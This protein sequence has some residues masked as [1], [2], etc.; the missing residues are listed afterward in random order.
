M[1]ISYSKRDGHTDHNIL[2][3]N[4]ATRKSGACNTTD[5]ATVQEESV[6]LVSLMWTNDSELRNRVG[7][8]HFLA[9]LQKLIYTCY[10]GEHTS[11]PFYM[12]KPGTNRVTLQS[13]RVSYFLRQSVYPHRF[14]V[15]HVP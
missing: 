7:F 6:I 3:P 4:S 9:L 5:L 8:G 12:H 14:V 1:F 10:P 13:K 2:H 11:V 15:F